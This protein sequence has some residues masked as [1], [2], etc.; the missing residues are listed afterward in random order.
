MLV[1]NCRINASHSVRWISWMSIPEDYAIRRRQSGEV[2]F[3]LDELVGSL[4]IRWTVFRNCLIKAHCRP[5]T[6]ATQKQHFGNSRLP[7]EEIHPRSDIESYSL[8]LHQSL[9]VVEP[10][11]HAKDHESPL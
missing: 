3:T 5:A 2:I 6:A 9:V 11:V 10:R 7:S 4:A 8:S 1:N